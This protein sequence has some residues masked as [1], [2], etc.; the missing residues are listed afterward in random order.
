[1]LGVEVVNPAT[2]A[3]R[4]PQDGVLAAAIQ[5]AAFANGLLIETGG[6]HS[7]V[8][9]FLPPLI[10]TKEDVGMILDK[11]ET[12]VIQAKQRRPSDA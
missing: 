12:A 4:A 8:L 7:A 5:R 11:L 3:V 2:H 1:M 9:R 10:L 6:R